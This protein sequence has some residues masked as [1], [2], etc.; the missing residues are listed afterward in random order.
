MI[1]E[2]QICLM[3]QISALFLFSFGSWEEDLDLSFKHRN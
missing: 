3:D 1:D 2:G